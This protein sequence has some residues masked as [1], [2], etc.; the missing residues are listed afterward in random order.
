[1]GLL[2]VTKVALAWWFLEPAILCASSSL[3]NLWKLRSVHLVTCSWLVS[4]GKML[5]RARPE[6]WAKG[7]HWLLDSLSWDRGS[8]RI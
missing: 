5:N 8:A 2:S 4:Q 3:C 6:L 7:H 1:M